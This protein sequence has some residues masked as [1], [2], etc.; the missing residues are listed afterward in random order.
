MKKRTP[1]FT[2]V[3]LRAH[4][5]TTVDQVGARIDGGNLVAIALSMPVLFVNGASMSD[6]VHKG[7]REPREQLIGK[8]S[9]STRY[10]YTSVLEKMNSFISLAADLSQTLCVLFYFSGQT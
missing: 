7:S 3:I 6:A 10:V 8:N 9:S 2:A 5:R 1:S 4:N